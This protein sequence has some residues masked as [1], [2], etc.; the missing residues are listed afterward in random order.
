M[1]RLVVTLFAVLLVFATPAYAQSFKSEQKAE[2]EQII[3]QYLLD[4]PGILYQAAENYQRDAAKRA[5]EDAV[6]VLSES[7]AALFANAD[8]PFIGN[9]KAKTVF[10]EFF[11][12]NCGYCKQAYPG[13]VKFLNEDKD[14]KIILVDSPI[15]SEQSNEAAKWAL[16]AKA[17]GKYNEF[18]QALM[19]FQGPKSEETLSKIATDLGLDAGALKTA[20]QSD[21]VRDR[22]VENMDLFQKLGLN[23]TPAFVAQDRVIRGYT[24]PE[25]LKQIADELRE[26]KAK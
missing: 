23:G 17:H 18:H 9:P 14:V 25:V 24:G 21:Q 4:N 20:A 5:D 11:D 19:Q 12:Y 15:L 13:L 7:G 8:L 2:I 22:L 3:K 6:K 16:A 1:N 10:V 26:G